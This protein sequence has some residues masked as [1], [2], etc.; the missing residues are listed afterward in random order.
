MICEYCKREL[1]KGE[2]CSCSGAVKAREGKKD[3]GAEQSTYNNGFGY[4]ASAQDTPDIDLSESNYNYSGSTNSSENLCNHNGTYFH[5]QSGWTSANNSPQQSAPSSYV[6]ANV[7]QKQKSGKLGIGLTLVIILICFVVPLLGIFSL[8]RSSSEDDPDPE[9]DSL[10]FYD[11]EYGQYASEALYDYELGTLEDDLY[12]NIWSNITFDMPRRYIEADSEEYADYETEDEDCAFLAYKDDNCGSII[13]STSNKNWLKYYETDELLDAITKNLT[14][15]LDIY[16][17]EYE[18][19]DTYDREIADATY[20]CIDIDLFDYGY[21]S[22]AIHRIGHGYI[23]F[24]I[25][26]NSQSRVDRI[27]DS[28]MPVY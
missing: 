7:P 13:I 24:T 22:V 23:Y 16:D 11:G 10:A 17:Y 6:Y 27:L 2:K 9:Y 14:E 4:G 12:V 5:E 15:S 1:L 25:I 20:L 28:V 8:I 21:M 3:S 18:I 26:E 19:G